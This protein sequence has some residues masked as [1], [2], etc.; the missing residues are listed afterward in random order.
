LHGV[1]TAVAVATAGLIRSELAADIAGTE[2]D[3]LASTRPRHRG[4]R[5]THCGNPSGISSQLH[6][7][8]HQL[9]RPMWP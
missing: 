5:R 9:Y 1:E 6:D 2:A 7:A 3:R 4:V 8:G